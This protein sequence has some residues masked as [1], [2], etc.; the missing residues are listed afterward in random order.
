MHGGAG[1]FAD[2]IFVVVATPTIG[3]CCRGWGRKNGRQCDR[4]GP[5]NWGLASPGVLA[6]KGAEAM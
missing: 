6:R 3:R 1:F 5:L 2:L 4:S